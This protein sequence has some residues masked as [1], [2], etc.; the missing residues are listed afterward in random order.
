[1]RVTGAFA[2]DRPAKRVAVA[3]FVQSS[4]SLCLCGK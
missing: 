4:V 1:M 3:R 2:F